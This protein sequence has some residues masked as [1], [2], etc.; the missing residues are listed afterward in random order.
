MKP[1]T[2]LSSP[3]DLALAPARRSRA[4][5]AILALLAIGTVINYLDRTV[6]GIAAPSL[7]KELGLSAGVMG[8]VFSAFSWTYTLSQIPAGLLLD[9][10]GAKKTYF[11]AVSGWSAFIIL[12]GLSGGLISLMIYRLGLG[13]AESPCFSANSRVVGHWFPQRERARATSI[14]QVGQYIGLAVF[15][16]LLFWIIESFG[17][18]AMFVIVGAVGLAFSVVWWL[19]YHEPHE[20]RTMNDAEREYIGAGGGLSM[21][22]DAQRP[23]SW[24]DVGRLLRRREIWGAAIGQFAGNSTVVFFLTWFPTYLVTER[25][26][27]WLK[28]GFFAILPFLGAS[29]GVLF[30]GWVSDLLLRRT[31]NVNLSRKLP[32]ITGLLLSACIVV[33]LYV[34]SDTAVIAVLSLAFFGQGMG[35]L[36]WSIIPDIA[37]KRLMGLTGG[38][39]NFTANIAGIVTPIVIGAIVSLTGSFYWG[40][41]FIGAVAILGAASYIFI[42]GDI[43]RI[44][45][46]DDTAPLKRAA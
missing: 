19:R 1:D 38:I 15:S 8:I 32:I 3:A 41:M 31:G 24:H 13:V 4:R 46:P 10:I 5:F 37:P 20:S 28:I 30:G 40:L 45:L 22:T 36:G 11:L 23:F 33:A 29:A 2:T 14:Y 12:N 44:E 26:M 9:R 6:L 42:L 34:Q 21:A 16:P 7:T 27:A 43:K 17:W 18:R 35:G 25:H 39:F